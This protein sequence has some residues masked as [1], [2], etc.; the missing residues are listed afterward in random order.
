ML[1]KINRLTTSQVASI[2]TLTGLASYFDGLKNA[3]E[4]DDISQIV[5]NLPVHSISHIVL[6]FEGGTFYNGKGLVPLSGAY[7]RPLMMTIFSLLYTLFGAHSFYFHLLQLLLCVASSLLL[8]LLFKH[9]FSTVLALVLAILFLI[10]PI[11]SQVVFAIPNMQDAL[12]FFFGMSALTLL[13]RSRSIASL[14]EMTVCLLLALLAKET[15]ILFVI[16]GAVYLIWQDR[17]RL[18]AYSTAVVTQLIVYVLLRTN[19]VGLFASNPNTAPIDRL[20]LA[21][22]LMNDP[23]IVFI[24]ISRL[25]F[26]YKLAI[27]YLW[28]YR[29]PSVTHFLL[30]LV[31]DLIT[32]CIFILLGYIVKRVAVKE[33]FQTYLFF[34]FWC[35]IGLAL[36]LQFVPLDS[37]VMEPW[38]YFSMAGVLGMIGVV[39]VTFQGKIHPKSFITIVIILIV[40]LGTRTALRGTDFRSS[41]VLAKADITASPENYVAYN[42]VATIYI[43]QSKYQTALPYARKAVAFF[44]SFTDYNNLGLIYAHQQNYI[45]ASNA[46]YKG[47]SYGEYVDLYDNIAALT[48]VYGAPSVDKAYI[49]QSLQTFPQDATLWMYLAILED[50]NGDNQDAKISIS[51]AANYG[52]ISAQLYTHIQSGLPF[53]MYTGRLLNR[54]IYVQ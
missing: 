38:F 4:G 24:Y 17:K 18:F 54:E 13:I 33:V 28:V 22:R 36:L 20:S 30:P 9:F 40:C 6:L 31:A 16:V 42:Q 35:C 39:L 7:Y 50:R 46:F 53:Y 21:G 2:L 1:E 15:A 49:I 37:T 43:N 14:C 25:I 27:N 32:I 44:P 29:H 3:F 51:N 52:T 10:H 5:S 11:D 48:L 12:Y 34:A 45:A 26:P 8:F 19:A 47:L 23:L 41:L